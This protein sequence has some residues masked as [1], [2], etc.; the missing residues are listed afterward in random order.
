MSSGKKFDDRPFLILCEGESD[1]RFFDK[2]IEK[3]HIEPIFQVRFPGREDVPR[4]GGNSNFGPW[5]SAA[6]KL[7]DF[8]TNIKAVLVVSDNDTD[9]AKSI[10]ALI[11]NLRQTGF[12][13]PQPGQKIAKKRGCPAVA[14]IMIPDGSPGNLETLCLAPFYTKWPIKP[15]LDTFLA[16]TPAATWSEG[17]KSKMQVQCLI[18][19]NCSSRPEAGFSGHWWEDDK[20]HL[21]LDDRAFDPLE[22]YL[23]GFRALVDSA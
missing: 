11:A 5:L 18:A 7:I 10:E 20:F 15:A 21:P 13:I 4:G 2:F 22:R 12:A 16:A 14:I 17:K 1:K 3:R 6:S 19:A 9:P 23:N 8:Q